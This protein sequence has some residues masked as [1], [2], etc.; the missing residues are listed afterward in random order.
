MGLGVRPG[1]GVASAAAFAAQLHFVGAVVEHSLCVCVCVCVWVVLGVLISS[2]IDKPAAPP[3]LLGRGCTKTIF[4]LWLRSWYGARSA[5]TCRCTHIGDPC[6]TQAIWGR[7]RVKFWVPKGDG[8]ASSLH[9]ATTEGKAC[10]HGCGGTC[11]A[12]MGD[13]QINPENMHTHLALKFACFHS[14]LPA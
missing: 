3:R 12:H 2:S 5:C 9:P 1:V 13:A 7:A 11:C 8:P 14:H 4:C 10:T 6:W